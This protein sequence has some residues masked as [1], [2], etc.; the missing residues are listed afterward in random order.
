MAEQVLV[1]HILHHLYLRPLALQDMEVTQLKV[2]LHMVDPEGVPPPME[3]LHHL[4]V[5]LRHHQEFLDQQDINNILS[6]HPAPNSLIL[7]VEF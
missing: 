2:N 4:M 5:V 7:Q 1:V 6:Y 3:E